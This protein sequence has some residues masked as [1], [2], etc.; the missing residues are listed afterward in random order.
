MRTYTVQVQH[1]ANA[2]DF[3]GEFQIRVSEY[4]Q[5]EGQPVLY[6]ASG[7]PFGCGKNASTPERAIAILLQDNAC[8]STKVI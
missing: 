4:A 1:Q 5:G 8:Y 2:K 3:T 7:R 6:Y